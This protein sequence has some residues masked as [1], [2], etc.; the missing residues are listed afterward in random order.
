MIDC[1]FGSLRPIQDEDLMMILTWRNAPTVRSN[2]Y[3]THVIN[4]NEHLAWWGRVKSSNNQ[5]YFL[6]IQNGNPSGVVSFNQ[7]DRIQN[8]NA[9]WAFY[10]SPEAPTGTGSRMEIMALDYAFGSLKLNK[11]CCEVLA[12]NKPVL[13]LHEKFGF[14]TEGVFREHHCHDGS[15]VD[16]YRL[17]ILIHEWEERRDSLVSK[18]LKKQRMNDAARN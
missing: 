9:F 4:R 13:K 11:L 18:L 8:R 6:Y 2:M 3:N 7:I 14:K 10:A 17:G 16:V 1:E 5:Q 12:F 15:L